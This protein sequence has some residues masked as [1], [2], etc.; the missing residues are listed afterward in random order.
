M[1]A[2]TVS[3]SLEKA[4]REAKKRTGR[5]GGGVVVHAP[6]Q[7]EEMKGDGVRAL[8]ELK[9]NPIITHSGLQN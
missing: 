1:I 6:H 3:F 5:A 9:A 7:E 4:E 8:S 2:T